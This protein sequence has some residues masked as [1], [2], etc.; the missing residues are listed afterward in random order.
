MSCPR[1]LGDVNSGTHNPGVLNNNIK[2]RM[3]TSMKA[4]INKLY[5][6]MNIIS[7]RAFN[8]PYFLKV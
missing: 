5:G 2:I 4:K 1:M 8:I 6:Q 7:Y 3:I